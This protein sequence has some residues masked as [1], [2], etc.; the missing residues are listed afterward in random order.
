MGERGGIVFQRTGNTRLRFK[1]FREPGAG[2]K[3]K[4]LLLQEEA[5]LYQLAV[6]LAAQGQGPAGVLHPG[7]MNAIYQHTVILALTDGLPGAPTAGKPELELVSPSRKVHTAALQQSCQLSAAVRR[8]VK[9]LLHARP[10][11]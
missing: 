4:M 1:R 6:E 5:S 8:K 3:D 11:Q 10:P 9:G 2:P 7:G